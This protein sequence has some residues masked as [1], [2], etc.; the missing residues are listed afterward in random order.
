[1]KGALIYFSGTGNTKYVIKKFNEEFKNKN[2]NCDLIDIDT[3]TNLDCKY[4]FYVFGAPIHAEMFPKN[5][6]TWVRKNVKNVTSKKCII[7]S[8]QASNK[9]T[10]AEELNLILK[11]KGMDVVIEDFIKMPNN[12]YIV[13][14]FKETPEE[15]KKSIKIN[16][17]KKISKLV[18][19]FLK[20]NKNVKHIS[21]FRVNLGKVSYKFFYMYSKNWAKKKLSVDESICTHCGKCVKECPTNNIKLSNGK[22]TFNSN[23]ISCQRCLNKCPVN[24]FRYKKEKFKQYKF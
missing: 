8:T 21:K 2:I 7:F 17:N 15:E 24:A 4:D 20:G 11:E 18:N 19:T 16:T 22:I 14:M 13:P 5:F 10:G 1:M 12:Y 3:N 9:G 6:I 23:C